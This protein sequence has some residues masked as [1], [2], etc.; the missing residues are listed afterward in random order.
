MKRIRTTEVGAATGR[1]RIEGWLHSQRNLGAI[2][3]LVIR[4]GWGTVQVVAP[5]WDEP[6]QLETVLAVEGEASVNSKAPGGV[7]LIDPRIEVISPVAEVM[8]ISLSKR[9]NLA[10]PTMLEHA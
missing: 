7:E 2:T 1:I 4:D 10:M 6:F 3:F 9:G 8:P 5:G